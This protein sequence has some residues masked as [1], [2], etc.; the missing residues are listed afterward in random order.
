MIPRSCVLRPTSLI[1]VL[2]QTANASLRNVGSDRDIQNVVVSRRHEDTLLAVIHEFQSTG[3]DDGES[4]AKLVIAQN[5]DLCPYLPRMAVISF[6][7]CNHRA[8][9]VAATSSGEAR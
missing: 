3:T 6:T 7:A 2:Q 5:N 8:S 1:H 4:K 9:S